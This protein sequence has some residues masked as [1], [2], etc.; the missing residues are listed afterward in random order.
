ME[1]D[2][3]LE[4]EVR[5]GVAKGMQKQ[6]EAVTAAAAAVQAAAVAKQKQEKGK[7]EEE[8]KGMGGGEGGE[9]KRG[10]CSGN[11]GE[12]CSSLCGCVRACASAGLNLESENKKGS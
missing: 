1:A 8:E 2:E 3:E 4:E 12:L 7:R 9:G 11:G 6:E 5:R 10:G